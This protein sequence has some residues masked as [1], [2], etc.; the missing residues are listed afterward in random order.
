MLSHLSKARHSK[1]LAPIVV[2]E[3][4]VTSFKITLLDMFN[5]NKSKLK[6]HLV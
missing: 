3:D 5:S 4:K 6:A 1:A 2:K